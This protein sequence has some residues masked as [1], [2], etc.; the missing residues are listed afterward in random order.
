MLT[1]LYRLIT[2]G[3]YHVA[4]L[5]LPYKL[6]A[7]E[8][9][10]RCAR[11][12][13]PI[14]GPVVWVHAASVGEVNAVASLVRALVQKYPLKKVVISTMT[15]TGL[16]TTR[17]LG[18]TAFLLPFDFPQAMQAVFT[19]LQPELLVI[20]ETELWPN[21]LLTAQERKIPVV[22]VNGRISDR[23][24]PRYRLLKPV[25]APL[26][27]AFTVA[28]ARSAE[29]ALRLKSIGLSKVVDCGNL[30]FN[31]HLPPV[32]VDLLRQELGYGA[33]DRILVFGSS[34]PGE[35]ELILGIFAGLKKEFPDLKLILAP[36][37]LTRL[38][39]VLPLLS[40][41]N[42]RLYSGPIAP[43]D[44]LLVDCLG[45]LATLYSIG[46]ICLVGGTFTKFTGHNPLEASYW[47][48][49][50]LMGP[51][52]HSCRDTVQMLQQAG[53]LQVCTAAELAVSIRT[54]LNNPEQRKRMGAAALQVMEAGSASLANHLRQLDD[55]LR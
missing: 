45:K 21:M 6:G 35:E 48:K 34:N 28:C 51:N 55:F 29:D 44:V 3:L 13:P 9:A 27:G 43:T 33:S 5:W 49:P 17:N 14:N 50:V 15:R 36:R 32:D 23:T 30:K 41:H 11:I 10:Q 54:L 46:E 8:A 26:L 53:A 18:F 4:R 19:R 38:P 42:Y 25:L 7:R 52:H 39:Q 16:K 2:A 47:G 31:L 40:T 22:L 37:H 12:L 1:D 24:L 20:M